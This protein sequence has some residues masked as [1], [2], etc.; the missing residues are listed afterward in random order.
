MPG[1]ALKGYLGVGKAASGSDLSFSPVV[2]DRF[3]R[4]VDLEFVESQS[5]EID[6]TSGRAEPEEA[7]LGPYDSRLRG[8]LEGTSEG[9]I[10]YLLRS[11]MGTVSTGA[12]VTGAYPHTFTKADSL[13]SANRLTFEKKYG[14]IAEAEYAN[15]VVKSMRYDF[16]QRGMSRWGFEALTTNPVYTA[17]PTSPTLPAALTTRWSFGM[18]TF[19]FGGATRRIRG[20]SVEI[21]NNAYDD[22]FDTT[23]R[24]RRDA[25]YGEFNVNVSLD[26]L[27]DD[28]TDLRRFW[29]GA[30][31]TGPANVPAL[32]ECNVKA[33]HP[34][35]IAGAEKHTVEFDMDKLFIT[36][37]TRRLSA[38]DVIMQTITGRALYDATNG[39]VTVKLKNTQATQ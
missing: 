37:V 28:L 5:E 4:Y 30:A 7:F 31:L 16:N 27:F 39:A 11:L 9:A 13:A 2:R 36:G 32:Y 22:D 35:A 34:T 23:S 38:K 12:A 24:S 10:G 19:T 18:H 17:S 15:G 3:C 33:E 25:D 14:T 26:M 6:P 1:H 8:T 29:G 21:D 20:G